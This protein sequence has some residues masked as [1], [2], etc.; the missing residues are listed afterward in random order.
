MLWTLGEEKADL[1][2]QER[3]LKEEINKKS[4]LQLLETKE[5]KIPIQT[6]E[7]PLTTTTITRIDALKKMIMGLLIRSDIRNLD[8]IYEFLKVDP[9][10]IEDIMKHLMLTGIVSINS[11]N[12]E[13]TELGMAQYKAG[14]ILSNPTSENL[15]FNYSPINKMVTEQEEQN[16]MV[17]SD[18]DLE[19]Y[20]Y[21]TNIHDIQGI[22]LEEQTVRSI[23][24]ESGQIFEIGGKEKIISK[25]EP[26]QL[27]DEKY[28][29]CIEFQLYDILE[30][31]AYSRVWNG[32]TGAWDEKFEMEIDEKES[33]S[34]KEQY[35]NSIAERFP[36]RYEMVKRKIASSQN[37]KS[38]D[39]KIDIIRGISIRKRFDQSFK[40]T[41]KKMLMVSPW[42]SE[43]VIDKE[44]FK[45][46]EKFSNENKTMYISWG[47]AKAFS[48][49][50]RRP[51]EELLNRIKNIK[52][53]D[54]TQAIFIRWF[55]NQH[56]KEI[57]IDDKTLLLGSY[58]WLSYRG[59][60]D[61][62]Q[63]SVVEVGDSEI[64]N[65]TTNFIEENFIT[66]LENELH[67]FLQGNPET[68]EILVYKNWM[69]ELILLSSSFEKRKKLSDELIE[70]LY[71][72]HKD[73]IVNEFAKLWAINNCE[74]F[75]VEK[76]L[77]D[78]L[79]QERLEEA[80]QFFDLCTKH[81]NTFNYL[82]NS[83]DLLE[84]KEW[85]EEQQ[86]KVHQSKTQQHKKNKKITS[87][88]ST[89]KQRTA[90][91]ISVSQKQKKAPDK[92]S[93]KGGN[94]QHKQNTKSDSKTADSNKSL[95]QKKQ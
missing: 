69:K 45:T 79:I 23:I 44:M 7:V 19:E 3:M 71:L 11:Q 76:H 21:E 31:K 95:K 10:F 80:E 77:K 89:K 73:I 49:E 90:Q 13:L 42:V 41:R 14:T 87:G 15:S 58:N 16:A 63:E 27:A 81:I 34:W 25:I 93:D 53:K 84:H 43:N 56:N 24:K 1:E 54:G 66:A 86:I 85:L 52:H 4:Y 64:I 22:T 12:Y 18:W 48:K 47:I 36:E 35:I 72:H 32:A 9:L 70:F 28:A 5:W 65:S 46:L 75:G 59:D 60:Y 51:S 78:L 61:L 29:K 2:Y 38:K 83:P 55:G 92:S 6:F 74:E 17:K 26:L 50:T 37:E 94:K 8:E 62:R 57:I 67:H 40:E 30:D 39:K 88:E 20:R 68:T 82:K 91:Q 33:E